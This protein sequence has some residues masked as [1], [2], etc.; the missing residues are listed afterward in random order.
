MSMQQSYRD[1]NGFIL[2]AHHPPLHDQEDKK[3]NWKAVLLTQI[4]AC[5]QV[6]IVGFGVCLHLWLNLNLI[7]KSSDGHLSCL[8]AW[9]RRQEEETLKSSTP[10]TNNGLS[11][12]LHSRVWGLPLSLVQFEFD[13]IIRCTPFLLSCRCWMSTCRFLVQNADTIDMSGRNLICR[14][15]MSAT[16]PDL[17]LFLATFLSVDTKLADIFWWK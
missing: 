16:L 7:K 4:M 6:C 5:Q 12:G 10:S 17:L 2:S 11:T 9:P 15:N 8:A 1:Q 14:P 3:R 13:Q